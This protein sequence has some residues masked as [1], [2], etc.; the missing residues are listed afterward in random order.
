[1]TRNSQDLLCHL[2]Y[3]KL[4]RQLHKTIRKTKNQPPYPENDSKKGENKKGEKK[5]QQQQKKKR[6]IPSQFSNRMGR[7]EDVTK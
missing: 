5:K 3:L 7:K 1:M 2:F 6:P 4:I